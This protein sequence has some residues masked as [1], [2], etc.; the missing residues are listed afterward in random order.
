M[1]GDLDTTKEHRTANLEQR[2]EASPTTASSSSRGADVS[3]GLTA[4]QRQALGRTDMDDG[5]WVQQPAAGWEALRESLRHFFASAAA[6]KACRC[7][8]GR[9]RLRDRGRVN[10]C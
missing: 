6:A 4:N 5:V 7:S 3:P 8:A 9:T 2:A 1:A 10:V